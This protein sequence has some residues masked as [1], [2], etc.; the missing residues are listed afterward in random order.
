M[1]HDH[2]TA[3]KI[4]D[5]RSKRLGKDRKKLTVEERR[6]TMSKPQQQPQYQRIGDSIFSKSEKI[7][8]ELFTL[9]YGAIV[10][11]LLQDYE[12]N[13]EEVNLQLEK[14]GYNIGG[15][16]IDEFL[17]KSGQGRCRDLKETAEVIAKIGFKM[18]LGVS[19]TVVG[20]DQKNSEFS[21]IIDDNPL[22]DFVELPDKYKTKLNYNNI[23]CGVI[24]GALEMVQMDVECKVVRDVLRGDEVSEIKVHLKG[25]LKEY[26]PVGED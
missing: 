10:W 24:R 9:T 7:S 11:Q 6:Q 18:F 21:L 15:R 14:M 4:T 19:A 16:L 3:S 23:L 12:D 20:F 8:A 17:A 2:S 5:H 25:Y 22:T 26:V 13:I 1:I